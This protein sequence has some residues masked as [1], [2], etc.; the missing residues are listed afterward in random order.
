MELELVKRRKL[1]GNICAKVR[2]WPPSLI[3]FTCMKK[4]L[5]ITNQFN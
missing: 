5:L 1:E 2:N 3:L 4:L